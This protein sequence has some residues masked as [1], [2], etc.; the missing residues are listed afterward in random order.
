MIAGAAVLLWVALAAVTY[1]GW[2]HGANHRDF[3][4]RWAGARL[5]VYEG[6]D[7]YSVET[8][9][10]M[11][12]MLY[13]AELPPEVDQQGFAYPA[14]QVPL[15]LPFWMVSN[16]EVAT[17]AWEATSILMIVGVLLLVRHLWGNAPRWVIVLLVLWYYPTLM[18]FQAQGTALPFAAVGVGAWAY[19]TRRDSL[20]GAVMV[21][22][23][24]KP[25]QVAIPIL[26]ILAL[27][28]YERRWR[29]PLA[30]I[31]AGSALFVVSL[32]LQG[33]WIPR[34]L[35]ALQRYAAY[36]QVAWS[37]NTAWHAHPLAAVALI[38]YIAAVVSQMRRTR[39][40]ALA[41]SVPLGMLLLPQTLIWGLM[42]LLIPLAMSWR[43]RAK[44]AV[45]AVW[46][47]GWLMILGTGMDGWWRVQSLLLP[48]MTLGVV[49]YASRQRT[50]VLAFSPDTARPAIQA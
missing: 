28:V 18:I 32:L 13:G 22:G 24:G 14:I 15:L 33:W 47:A 41:A 26:I 46:V 9:R 36:A 45:L 31:A 25:E 48:A 44:W 37:F 1:T 2:I 34:W 50:A 12:V 19:L 5:A 39:E 4:P 21:I 10:A 11:Q 30:L 40:A 49:A 38:A 29:I 43:G 42:M 6:R 17:A 35:E 20:A 7:L 3:Y 27:A 8:T 16:V 23:L